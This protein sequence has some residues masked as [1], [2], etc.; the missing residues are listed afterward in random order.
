MGTNTAAKTFWFFPLSFYQ[1]EDLRD[2]L[3][4]NSFLAKPKFGKGF[5][6]FFCGAK[7]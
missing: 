7:D 2:Y 1:A 4:Y 3:N 5:F 6:S